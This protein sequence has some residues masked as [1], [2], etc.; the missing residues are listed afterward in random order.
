M[1]P[2]NRP[3]LPLYQGHLTRSER[4]RFA[5]YSR[6]PLDHEVALLRIL[7]ERRMARLA[8]SQDPEERASLANE[9]TRTAIL[10]AR[11]LQIRAAL[12][13][14][15]RDTRLEEIA[16]NLRAAFTSADPPNPIP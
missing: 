8:E 1:S 3:P 16:A 6:A 9:L 11:L 5:A 10:V 4:Q 2:S 13:Q 12:G 14:G 15:E 7:N